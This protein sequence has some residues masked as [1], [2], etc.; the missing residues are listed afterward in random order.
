MICK[1]YIRVYIGLKKPKVEHSTLIGHYEDVIFRDADFPSKFKFIN[2]IW[3]LK[4]LDRSN[5]HPWIP[6]AFNSI[7]GKRY[8]SYK[9]PTFT[10]KSKPRKVIE[11]FK[12]LF[13]DCTFKKALDRYATIYEFP[14]N[15]IKPL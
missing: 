2:F 7:N 13:V 1:Q 8:F 12:H 11:K 4:M 5:F 14:Y 10:G 15:F 9:L 3:I 6:I